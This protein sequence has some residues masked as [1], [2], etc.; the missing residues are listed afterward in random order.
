VITFYSYN[1]LSGTTKRN[2]DNLP[3]NI[4]A[5][6]NIRVS[7]KLTTIAIHMVVVVINLILVLIVMVAGW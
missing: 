2:D 7:L 3:M 5:E 4:T 6:R 1:N